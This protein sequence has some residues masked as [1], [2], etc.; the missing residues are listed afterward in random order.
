MNR[1]STSDRPVSGRYAGW[2]LALLF[3]L[4]MLDYTDR[5]IIVSLFPF[6]KSDWG[7]SDTQCGLLVSTVYWSILVF[8][9][10]VSILVDRWSRKKSIGLMALIWSL[11]T[12]ACAFTR[13]FGQLFAA[14]T[15]I[16]VGEAGYAP[17][18]TA[19][20]SALYP[21]EKRARMLGIWNASIPLGSALGI[22]IGGFAA[23]HFGWRN[24]FGLVA[25]PGMLAAVLCFFIRDYRTVE[26]SRSLSDDSGR[27]QARLTW[28]EIVR[29]FSGNR[30]LILNNLGFAANVFVTTS[31]LTW[32]PTYFHRQ[33]GLS[34][35]QAG[36]KGG[37]VMMLAIIGAPLGGYLA[38]R[39]FVS[40]RNARLLF[41]ALTSFLTGVLLFSA[42]AFFKG[43]SQYPI[44][45]AAGA[46][47]VAFVPAS[48]AVTQ[49][50]VHSGLRA[51]SLSVNVI[52]QH[53]L[54]SSLGPTFVGAM[55][56]SYSLSAGLLCL[57]AFCILASGLYFGASFYYERDAARVE[58]EEVCF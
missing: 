43:P 18:G 32:L 33:Y 17:G 41:P 2:V 21:K 11:A 50:V 55:S 8:S 54:G 10:P 29:M 23:E 5:L 16:G 47:A 27:V 48:V 15:A 34:M 49:D 19:M 1:G 24:A 44:L 45:L 7:L 9:F 25:A 56:D 40:R 3:L 58:S 53:L 20:I 14:R 51:V 12:L 26:L 28:L 38:D 6:L 37:L 22:G 36:V 42:F 35:S 13:N 30:T 39:W 52:I 4:Y 57:P 46:M 31:L